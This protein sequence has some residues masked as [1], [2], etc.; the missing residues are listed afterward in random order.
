[1]KNINKMLM[2]VLVTAI[3]LSSCI[4]NEVAPEVAALRQAQLDMITAK[5]ELQNLLNEAQRIEN[6][7]QVLY[8]AYRV[9][10]NDLDL[11]EQ[12]ADLQRQLAVIAWQIVDAEAQLEV[13]RLQLQ[14]A[15]DALAIY[16]AGNGFAEAAEYLGNYGAVMNGGNVYLNGAWQYTVVRS[17]NSVLS[18]ILGKETA[19][20]EAQLLLVATGPDSGVPWS[21]VIAELQRDLTQG[22]AALAVEQTILATLQAIEADPTSREVEVEALRVQVEALEATEN[23]LTVLGEELSQAADA[24]EL[25]FE[26]AEDMITIMDGG[27]FNDDQSVNDFDWNN[28]DSYEGLTQELANASDTQGLQDNINDAQ[29]DIDVAEAELIVLEATLATAE[30]NLAAQEAILAPLAAAVI[31]AQATEDAAQST[32]DVENANQTIV[33]N[34]LIAANNDLTTADTDLDNAN[35]AVTDALEDVN[36]AEYAVIDEGNTGALQAIIDARQLDIDATFVPDGFDGSQQVLDDA[37]IAYNADPSPANYTAMINAQN[38]LAVDQQELADA[39]ADLAQ[40]PID[41]TD[42]QAALVDAQATQTAATTAQAAATTAV[43]NAQT[44]VDTQQVITDAAQAAFDTAE[45]ATD[46]AEAQETVAETN[47]T[48]AE[49]LVN[50]AQLLIYDDNGTP[51]NPNDDSGLVFDIG[52]Y[53]G[54]GDPND[55]ANWTGLYK[56][57]FD[58][59]AALDDANET[60]ADA[61]AAIA[62]HQADYDAAVAGIAALETTMDADATASADNTALIT[63]TGNAIG[64]LE[65]IIFIIDEIFLEGTG[66][67]TADS[68]AVIADLITAQEDAIETQI[69][70]NATIQGTIDNG[71]LDVTQAN[72][73]ITNMQTEL[74]QLNVEYNGLLANA[75]EWLALMNAAI[76]G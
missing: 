2:V 40:L 67:G 1:M 60:I 38:A 8:D 9:A 16:L 23:E 7:Y 26:E 50:A 44:D 73:D 43:T 63:S 52:G 42:A 47:V 24:S 66:A 28:G 20:A 30:T 64:D 29:A 51:N 17:A 10:L 13:E 61:T 59:N 3:T 74:A 11:Q 75:A 4:K 48:A 62:A 31:T 19:I 37:V 71:N 39:Q 58:A 33:D 69:R 76:G 46:A 56:T 55:T 21:V 70:S 34:V 25:A 6:A 65:D 49:G 14:Q 15:I 27:V 53:D 54:T 35:T 36:D 18:E 41:V 5:I 68:G 45:A 57:L 22:E 72:Q 32:L 12:T